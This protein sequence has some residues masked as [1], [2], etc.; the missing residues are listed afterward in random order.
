MTYGQFFHFARVVGLHNLYDL[1]RGIQGLNPLFDD[2]EFR[3]ANVQRAFQ[4][5]K[6]WAARQSLDHFHFVLG[7]VMGDHSECLEMLIGCV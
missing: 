4:Y 7:Q 1:F 5:L 2:G 6:L 3:T